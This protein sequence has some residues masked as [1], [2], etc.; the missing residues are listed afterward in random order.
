MGGRGALIGWDS[1]TD[2]SEPIRGARPSMASH[3]LPRPPKFGLPS[4]RPPTFSHV[5]CL[6]QSEESTASHAHGLR[7]ERPCGRPIGLSCT[8]GDA[9]RSSGEAA[10]SAQG[11]NSHGRP[12][13]EA[14]QTLTTSHTAS[15]KVMW[16]VRES[17]MGGRGRPSTASHYKVM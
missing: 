6:G 10:R 7:S 15:H 14:N 9:V 17:K 8:P 13:C 2:L 5:I 3:G 1:L 16:S 4:P 12:A 11:S